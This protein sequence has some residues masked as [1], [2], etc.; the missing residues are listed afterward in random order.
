MKKSL[1]FLLPLGVAAL[2]SCSNE[3]SVTR[4]ISFPTPV[5]NVITDLSDGTTVASAGIYNFS[6]N[7]IDLTGNINSTDLILN[8]SATTLSIDDS[9]YKSNGIYAE[10]S[11][12]SGNTS[13]STSLTVNSAY[14][15]ALP[16][17]VFYS[18]D[19]VG[20]LYQP[21]LRSPWMLIAQYSLGTQYRVRAFRYDSTFKGTTNTTYPTTKDDGTTETTSYSTKEIEYRVIMDLAN[22]KATMLI[23]NPK[24]SPLTPD[25]QPL[26]LKDLTPVF[27][28]QGV[29]ISGTNVVPEMPEGEAGASTTP[30]PGFTFNSITFETTNVGLTDASITYQVAGRYNGTF[31]GSCLDEKY[32]NVGQ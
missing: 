10:F 2:S 23:Y 7:T 21:S 20:T 16:S 4:N 13:G 11:N 27:T 18:S 32:L 1:L 6:L 15:M 12:V 19:K 30:F 5:I 29:T 26:I 31:A 28:P 8:N 9:P 25:L 17:D 24:F 22:N 3:S 14:F